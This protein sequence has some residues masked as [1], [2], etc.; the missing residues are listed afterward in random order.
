MGEAHNLQSGVN[1]KCSIFL[2]VLYILWTGKTLE[3]KN[4]VQDEKIT[5][6][7]GVIGDLSSKEMFEQFKTEMLEKLEEQAKLIAEQGERSARQDAKIAEQDVKI[8]DQ[9]VKIAL[10]GETIANQ[11]ERIGTQE[12]KSVEQD[13]KIARQSETIA[14]LEETI[15]E[16]QKT[17]EEQ[18]E[19]IQ[20]IA[21]HPH[22][23][24]LIQ[25]FKTGAIS[26]KILGMPKAP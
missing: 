4:V 22:F 7:E 19:T 17:I 20:L 26:H 6:L 14:R 1:F 9:D 15:A 12:E 23:R 5:S 2:V 21:T 3:G 11:E 10:Q 24:E 8:A 18:N 16:Q 25:R 13:L